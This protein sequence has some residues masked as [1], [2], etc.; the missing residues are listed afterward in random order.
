MVF[1]CHEFFNLQPTKALLLP[2]TNGK[3]F[4]ALWGSLYLQLGG[5]TPVL[6]ATGTEAYYL[7]LKQKTGATARIGIQGPP[8]KMPGFGV[9]ET[10]LI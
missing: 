1:T 6:C 8:G 7:N 10:W 5:G 2:K 3:K 4:V 9:S